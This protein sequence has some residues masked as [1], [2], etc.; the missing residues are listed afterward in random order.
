MPTAAIILSLVLMTSLVGTSY[1]LIDHDLQLPQADY[2]PPSSGIFD[3]PIHATMP[4]DVKR[5]VIFGGG[6]VP[7]S[8]SAVYRASS[9]NGFFA[10]A[11]ISEKEVPKLQSDGYYIVEDFELD[12]HD[13]PDGSRI[14]AI[15]GSDFVHDEFGYTGDGVTVAIVDTGVDFSNLDLRSSL[16]RDDQN[17]PV[18]LDPDGQG[19]ILTNNTFYAA[20]DDDGLLLDTKS[21]PEEAISSVYKNRDG[22][23]LDIAQGG[24]GTEISIYNSFFPQAGESAVFHAKLTEDIKIGNDS[25]DYIVSKSGYYHLGMMYQGALQGS[26]ARLQVVPVLVVDA[27]LPGVYDT[28]IP[29]LSTSWQDY[30]RYDLPDGQQPQYDFDFTDEKPIVLGSGNEFLV[31]DSDDDGRIDYSAGTIGARVLDV[32]GVIENKTSAVERTYLQSMERCFTQ[33]ILPEIT[34]V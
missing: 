31:Y 2:M 10:I 5:Y 23:F 25:H 28:V 14:G 15:T 34:L 17:H 6:G 24:N 8:I 11:L 21:I 18:M 29:D 33:L 30:T 32:Y 12:F 3:I 1:A 20:I 19:I 9:F 16:L 13:A 27:N 22:I 26:F 4:F 7:D